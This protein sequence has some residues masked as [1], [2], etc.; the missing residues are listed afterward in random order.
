MRKRKLSVH[1]LLRFFG[2]ALIHIVIIINRIAF[3]RYRVILRRHQFLLIFVLIQLYHY[4]SVQL[5]TVAVLRKCRIL[6]VSLC[7]QMT[8]IACEQLYPR[9]TLTAVLRHY[10]LHLK[11]FIRMEIISTLR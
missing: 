1:N 7:I 11:Y 5:L 8:V 9:I 10:I 4:G 6:H 2:N 3:L